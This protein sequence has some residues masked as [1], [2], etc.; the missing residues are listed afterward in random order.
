MWKAQPCRDLRLVTLLTP[1]DQTRDEAQPNTSKLW[2]ADRRGKINSWSARISCREFEWGSVELGGVSPKTHQQ[3]DLEGAQQ[4]SRRQ[5]RSH[6]ALLSFSIASCLKS[7]TKTN[8]FFP[9]IVLILSEKYINHCLWY[10]NCVL[11]KHLT[12]CRSYLEVISSIDCV[13]GWLKWTLLYWGSSEDL[14]EMTLWLGVH[15]AA[16]ACGT[17][18]G[19]QVRFTGD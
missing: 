4:H 19:T 2:L 15:H 9:F 1:A 3:W 13:S 10:H 18:V 12:I 8:Q 16:C 14:L 17:Q 7:Y 11:L 5:R 6:C